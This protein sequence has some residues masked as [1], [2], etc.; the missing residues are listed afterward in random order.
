MGG[1][2]VGVLGTAVV[3]T[4]A[5][6]RELGAAKHRALLSVL[7]LRRG[8]RVPAE[9]I[10]AALWG[11]DPPAGAAGTLQGYVADLRRVLEPRRAPREA[12]T[13]LVTVPGGYSLR[14]DADA[15]DAARF[16]TVVR[17]AATELQAIAHPLRP[18]VPPDQR[19]AVAAA[20]ELLDEA[21]ALWRG[22]PLS[23]LG[24][25]VEVQVERDRL[26]ALRLD[27]EVLRLTALLA[28]GRHA[29]AVTD[30]ERLARANPWNERLWGLRALAL[31]G[32]GRQAEALACLRELRAA[33]SGELG[34]DPGIELRELETALIRQE[35]PTPPEP[36]A[37]PRLVLTGAP[38]P[39]D[40]PAAPTE[41]WPMVGRRDE[42]RT[43]TDVLDLA[44]RH[45]AQL[46]HLTGEH[47]LGK[48]RLTRRVEELAADRG[49]AVAHAGCAR[50]ARR[51]EGWA[52]HRLERALEGAADATDAVPPPEDTTHRRVEGGLGCAVRAAEEALCLMQVVG[53]RAP[54]LVVLEDLQWAD[55]STLRALSHLVANRPPGPFVLLLTQRLAP[56]ASS[57]AMS[58]LLSALG[59]AHGVHLPLAGLEDD[60]VGGLLEAVTGT[61]AHLR[62]AGEVARRTDGNPFVVVEL[63]RHG[64]PTG[65][66]P[67]S[68]RDVVAHCLRGLPPGTLALLGGA[69]LLGRTFDATLL[70]HA[71]DLRVAPAFAL[72]APATAAGILREDGDDRYTFCHGVVREALAGSLTSLPRAR[73]HA[74]FARVL[75]EKRG[76]LERPDRRAAMAGHWRAAG[77][78]F[79]AQAW[80]AT[81]EAARR[82]LADGLPDEAARLLDQAARA[83]HWDR[84]ATAADVRRLGDIEALVSATTV[85]GTRAAGDGPLRTA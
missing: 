65:E 75:E 40:R 14:L 60:E 21:L 78:A 11:D 77:Y 61:R 70:A 49:F 51:T 17:R 16:E 42:L 53:E 18:V 30:L 56:V 31:A 4:D 3:T 46:V 12:P 82:A 33:L 62:V 32:S 37:P 45:A 74:S 24:A 71:A 23:D 50:D 48:T 57:A 27:A 6:R 63:A 15:V 79:T 22:E 83:Q 69:A 73:W 80:R 67:S 68:V 41:D 55:E 2:E 5:T 66:L 29:Q 84:T 85:A 35:L 47:G 72:L 19:P 36:A 54:L 64:R 28:L 10:V 13:V 44:S 76:G 52:W 7:A 58:A 9:A 81:A 39:G 34:I 59:R 1:V 38:R 43:L 25:D 20:A 26:H 8:A